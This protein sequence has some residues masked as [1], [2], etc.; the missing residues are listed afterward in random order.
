MRHTH[1]VPHKSLTNSDWLLGTAG[2]SGT[3]Q[4]SKTVGDE[5]HGPVCLV[6]LS[7][8]GFEVLQLLDSQFSL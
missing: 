6:I 2:P 8:L 4:L 7:Y 5:G 1:C 3:I